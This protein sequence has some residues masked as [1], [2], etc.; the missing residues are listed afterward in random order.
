MSAGGSQLLTAVNDA[1]TDT[2]SRTRALQCTSM[3][4][5]CDVGLVLQPP[6]TE[7][8]LEVR[9]TRGPF[10]CLATWPSVSRRASD[11]AD[12]RSSLRRTLRAATL[13]RL[14]PHQYLSVTR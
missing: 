5:E 6:Q 4:I 14:S 7:C 3:R 1:H 12:T 8:E 9:G 11:V 2:A 10:A 13:H